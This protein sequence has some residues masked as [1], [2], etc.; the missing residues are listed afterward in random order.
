MLFHL[1]KFMVD[2]WCNTA[3]RALKGNIFA[4][5]LQFPIKPVPSLTVAVEHFPVI[6]RAPEEKKEAKW[7]PGL[8]SV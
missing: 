8:T 7:F 2:C 1:L 4:E 6:I 3:H 5:P